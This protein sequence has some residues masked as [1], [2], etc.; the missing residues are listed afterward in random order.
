MWNSIRGG[1]KHSLAPGT[2]HGVRRQ[3]NVWFVSRGG[4]LWMVR[5]PILKIRLVCFTMGKLVDGPISD[6]KNSSALFH[7][8]EASG[9]SDNGYACLG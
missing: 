3:K 2:N 8:G 1:T 7:D 5:S 4:S 9:W 6:T